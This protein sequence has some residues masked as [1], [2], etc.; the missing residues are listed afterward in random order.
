MTAGSWPYFARQCPDCRYFEAEPSPFIDDTGY[1]VLGFCR[2]PRI[3]ME[4]FRPKK[5]EL[6]AAERCP[7]FVRRVSPERHVT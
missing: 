3:G 2:Q 1:E 6:P 7:V 4:L 5:L